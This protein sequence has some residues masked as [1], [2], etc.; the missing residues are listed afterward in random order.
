MRHEGS[1]PKTHPPAPPLGLVQTWVSANGNKCLV[2]G[3][4][5]V[6]EDKR[7]DG[8]DDMTCRSVALIRI[9]TQELMVLYKKLN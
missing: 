5:V 4:N 3:K 8:I 2:P 7:M 9:L 1:K 6:K